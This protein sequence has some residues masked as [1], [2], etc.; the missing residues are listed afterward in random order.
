MV[1]ESLGSTYGDP[2]MSAASGDPRVEDERKHLEGLL[3][4]RINF[5]IIFASVFVVGLSEIKDDTIRVAALV[6]MTVVSSLIGLAVIRTHLLVGKALDEITKDETHPYYRFQKEVKF[7]G[8]ANKFL[9]WVPVILTTF[10]L[11]VTI[12][13]SLRLCAH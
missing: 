8:N 11:C 2:I 12:Y 3:K 5:Y 10:F 7:P 13:Y 1:L 9:V 4:D 6:V